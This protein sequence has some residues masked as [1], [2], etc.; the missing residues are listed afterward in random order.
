MARLRIIGIRTPQSPRHTVVSFHATPEDIRRIASIDRIG[1]SDTGDLSGFQ[2]PQI[3]SHIREIRDY[4][5]KIDSV[6]PNPIVIAFT[7]GVC[8]MQEEGDIVTLEVDI[9]NGPVGTVV[10]G[11]QRLSAATDLGRPG[12]HLLVSALICPDAEEL[13]RQFVLINNTRPLP[14]SLIY[15][16]LP[17]VSGLPR[18]LTSRTFAAHLTARL[19]YESSSLTGYILQHTNPTGVI[20]DTAIQ[21]A[22]MNSTS[23]GALRELMHFPDGEET[24]FQ[25]ISEF[26]GAVQEVFDS[27]WFGHTPK[28][29]R[30]VH[31]AGIVAMG[32]VMETLYFRNSARTR[33]EFVHGLRSLEGKTAWTS[34]VWNFAIDDIRPWNRVQNTRREIAQLAEYLIRIVKSDRDN[35]RATA[36]LNVA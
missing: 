31:G 24:S 17:T 21:K 36:S 29:S 22:I 15:E 10:D 32:Y 19:N 4:L 8:V 18:R 13:R 23:D 33:A 16:L 27:E 11:Q 9:S 6:L 7:D 20:R 25:L 26:F 5:M 12:F 2:R 30:L 35:G 3:A 34:G 14:K 1:R 28:T